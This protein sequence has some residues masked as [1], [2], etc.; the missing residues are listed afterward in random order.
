[1][2]NK[3]ASSVEEYIAAFPKEVQM[4]L[5]QMRKTII[6]AAPKAVEGI[7]Y[8]MPGYKHLGKPLVY[9]AGYVNHIGFYATPTGHEAFKKDLAKY[10]QGKGS[11]QFPITEK[12]PLQLVE[13]IT[14]FRLVEN[15]TK[16]TVKKV[17]K[18]T[19]VSGIKKNSPK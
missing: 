2:K 7:F 11:V 3:I 8:G 6:S 18:K 9:F 16:T 12:L 15:E 1:M 19:A 10:K 5:N 14:K 17:V 13:K 4:L